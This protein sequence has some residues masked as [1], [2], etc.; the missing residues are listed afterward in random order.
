MDNPLHRH[1]LNVICL[2]SPLTN[3]FLKAPFYVLFF[4]FFTPL[5]KAL[6][7]TYQLNIIP[8]LMSVN[9]SIFSISNQTL[10]LVVLPPVLWNALQKE[11][12]RPTFI[13]LKLDNLGLLLHFLIYPHL[14]FSKHKSH[15]FHQS[16]PP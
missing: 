10:A 4:S 12:R 8:M 1:L 6:S 13:L 3:V 7:P 11:F 14:N 2:D 15:L 16:F 9:C 5:H